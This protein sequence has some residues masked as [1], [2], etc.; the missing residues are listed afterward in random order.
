MNTIKIDIG[1]IEYVCP[2]CDAPVGD[3]FMGKGANRIAMTYNGE[4]LEFDL[5]DRCYPKITGAAPKAQH[6][7]L[8][9]ISRRVMKKPEVYTHRNGGPA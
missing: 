9:I 6:K 5:C 3:D 8:G 2:N 1:K 4:R 7:R